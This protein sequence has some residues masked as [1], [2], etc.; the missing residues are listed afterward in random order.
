[1]GFELAEILLS[2]TSWPVRNFYRI[3]QALVGAMVS[4]WSQRFDKFDVAA[5]FVGDDNPGYSKLG[6]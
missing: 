5:Q 4:I 3:V 2:F 1:M 6:N